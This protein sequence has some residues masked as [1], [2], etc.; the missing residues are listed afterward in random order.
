MTVCHYNDKYPAFLTTAASVIG[1]ALAAAN[2]QAQLEEVIVTAQKRAESLQDIPVTL[3]AFSNEALVDF[4]ITDTQALQSITPGLV[5]NNSGTSAQIYLRGVGTRF[6]FAGLDPSVATYVDD[7]YIGRAQASIFDFADVERIEVLKGPQGTLYG[8]NATGGAIRVVTMDVDDELT[9]KVT[10]TA[11]NY[12][13]WGFSGTV[14]VPLTDD[15]GVRLSGL[16]KQRDGYAD[17]LDPRG[18]AELDDQ[19]YQS[20]KAKFRWDMSD[21]WT[22]RLSLEYSNR[23]DLEGSDQVDISPPGLNRAVANGGLSG[24]DVDEV[25]TAT[26]QKADSEDYAATLRL[27]GVFDAFDFA[28][29]TTY[30]DFDLV[31]SVDADG[32]SRRDSDAYRVPQAAESFSQELQWLSNTGGDWNWIV[33]LYYF[34]ENNRLFELEVGLQDLLGTETI[35]TQGNQSSLT[36]AYAG[37]GQLTYDFNE[38]WSLTLGGRYSSEEK[39]VAVKAPSSTGVVSL[40]PY[41]FDDEADWN[42]FTPKLTLEYNFDVGMAYL[43]YAR[44]FKSG[45]FNYPASTPNPLTGEAQAALDPEILDMIELGWKTELLDQRLRFNGALF[46]YDYQDLQV[47]RGVA[48]D[49]GAVFNVTENAANAEVMGLDLDI[50]W[51]PTDR[52][53]LTAGLN[54]LDSEYQDFA[55]SANIFNNVVTP[56]RPGM[57]TVAFDADGESLLRA[58][59]WS[60][61][62]SVSYEF[63]AGDARIPVVLTY[64]YKDDYNY[65]FVA[66]PSSNALIQEGYGLLSARATYVSPSET[67]QVA[68]WG[69]NLTDEDEY[70]EDVVGNAAG[71]RGSHGA[72]LT[73]GV[74]VMYNF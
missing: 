59:D 68:V 28:S 74:D 37:F 26:N 51:L 64:A 17:N 39:E 62:A 69:K 43:S 48:D 60:A 66:H 70:F 24:N 3:Q 61:F 9:G 33:G 65:D 72:P 67:W 20:Y 10:A 71:I 42:E 30:W 22:G 35:F 18:V 57:T 46:Y 5:V 2:A 7:R 47:T 32:T 29:I 36:T 73:Y 56:G 50:T 25:Y 16:V 12:D 23:N 4:G 14:S 38:A 8:R 34:R 13:H 44:G 27:D 45:G 54:L 6:A 53:I 11:G 15:L 1:L 41:P 55:A 21:T 31:A 63:S 58:P 52:L 19:D 49:N 40:V